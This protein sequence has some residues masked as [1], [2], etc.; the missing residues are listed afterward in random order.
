MKKNTAL[1]WLAGLTSLAGILLVSRIE[2]IM[3]KIH[4]MPTPLPGVVI[5]LTGI[6]MFLLLSDIFI[7]ICGTKEI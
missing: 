2:I 6:G 7:A 5:L 1:N 4:L 3:T